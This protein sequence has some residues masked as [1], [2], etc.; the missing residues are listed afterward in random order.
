MAP[1][2]VWLEFGQCIDD[3]DL[4]PHD[5]VWYRPLGAMVGRFV[6]SYGFVPHLENL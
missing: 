1:R 2:V 3:L 6:A 4:W 5:E